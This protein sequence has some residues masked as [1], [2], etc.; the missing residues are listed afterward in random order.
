MV[1]LALFLLTVGDFV[2]LDGCGGCVPPLEGAACGA[3]LVL[4]GESGPITSFSGDCPGTR[5]V[6]LVKPDMTESM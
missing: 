2:P 5:T 4:D 3:L 1:R 6:S